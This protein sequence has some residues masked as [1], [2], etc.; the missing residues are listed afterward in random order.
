MRRIKETELRELA[1]FLM[2]QFF[3]K[4]EMQVMM[5]G[6][7]AGQAKQLAIDLVCHELGYFFKYGDIFIYD[8]AITGAI[9]GIDAKNLSFWKQLP[10]AWKG[11]QVIS[12][13]GKEMLRKIKE[14][15]KV[16][17]EVHDAKWY[18]RYLNEKPYY[19]AQFGIAKQARGQGIARVML[20]ALF[21]RVKATTSY[22]V[23]ETL[24]PENVPMYEHFGFEKM[25]E[26][27]T[28]DKQL[29]EYR[30]LRKI[31]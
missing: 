27:E 22:V 14:N 8:E 16:I 26:Y 23:L 21:E 10:Y 2:D 31:R 5:K 28:R 25:E 29:T 20:E 3:E 12:K 6:F 30:M 17:Q 4:E 19:I 1:V 18:R 15:A 7:D 13:V 11:N 24:S 9:V